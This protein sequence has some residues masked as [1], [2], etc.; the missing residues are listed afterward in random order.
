MSHVY[1]EQRVTAQQAHHHMCSF[2]CTIT[3]P[4]VIHGTG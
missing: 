2:F 1:L 4:L 3:I